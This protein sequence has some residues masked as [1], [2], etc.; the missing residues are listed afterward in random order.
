MMPPGMAL[1]VSGVFAAGI[2]VGMLIRSAVDW[3][4]GRRK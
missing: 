1:A 2:S 4:A 3:A